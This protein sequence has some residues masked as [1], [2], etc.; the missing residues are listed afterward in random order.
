MESAVGGNNQFPIIE[1]AHVKIIHTLEVHNHLTQTRDKVFVSI[2]HFGK[3]VS[4][5]RIK[6]GKFVSLPK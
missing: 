3:S 6:R 4:L 5:P 1:S 2:A